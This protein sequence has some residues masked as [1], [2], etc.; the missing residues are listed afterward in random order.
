VLAG[1]CALA[2]P[3]IIQ[4][5]EKIK[6]RLFITIVSDFDAN[7]GKKTHIEKQNRKKLKYEKVF[8]T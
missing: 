4:I 6:R 1:A 5:S 8:E 2:I 7:V 3:A